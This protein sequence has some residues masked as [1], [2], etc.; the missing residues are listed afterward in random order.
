MSTPLRN[1]RVRRALFPTP[2]AKRAR[3]QKSAIVKTIRSL[4]ETKTFSIDGPWLTG[5][6]ASTGINVEMSLI[7]QGVGTEERVGNVIHNTRL[8]IR[9]S[10]RDVGVL[11]VAVVC[12]K[13]P[14]N[15]LSTTN[16]Q[17]DSIDLEAYWVIHDEFFY[18]GAD[19]ATVVNLDIPLNHKTHFGSA[20]NNDWKKNPL[21]VF[22]NKKL[23]GG[24]SNIEGYI[25]VFYKDI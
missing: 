13:D 4:A 17:E 24:S 14:S 12:P 16:Q 11:R 20:A 1:T 19:Q 25:Q 21:K 5:T 9:L 15:N 7:D 22:I 10:G 2:A 8:R 3:S 6:G 23:N 18:G